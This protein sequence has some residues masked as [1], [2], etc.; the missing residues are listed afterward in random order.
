MTFELV[1]MHNNKE[2][3]KVWKV[4]CKIVKHNWLKI[5]SWK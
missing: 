1:S 2:V 4:L 3:A 5:I